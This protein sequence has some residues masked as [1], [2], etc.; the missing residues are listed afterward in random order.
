MKKLESIVDLREVANLV[1]T[2]DM[3]SALVISDCRTISTF[4]SPTGKIADGKYVTMD[5]PDYWNPTFVSGRTA[6]DAYHIGLEESVS[7]VD[8]RGMIP[9]SQRIDASGKDF[10]VKRIETFLKMA[11]TTRDYGFVFFIERDGSSVILTKYYVC[12]NKYERY[13]L[14]D[15]KTFRKVM[16]YDTQQVG[17]AYVPSADKCKKAV[18]LLKRKDT[19]PFVDIN[20]QE[21]L[22]HFGATTYETSKVLPFTA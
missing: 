14:E 4:S 17:Q 1:E 12:K 9:F 11:I 16:G 6:Y 22:N 20:I 21:T 10:Y 19:A 7:S 8:Y 15:I 3:V 13:F 2:A 5:A 18:S